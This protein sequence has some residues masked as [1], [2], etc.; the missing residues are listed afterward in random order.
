MKDTWLARL[1]RRLGVAPLEGVQAALVALVQAQAQTRA[2]LEKVEKE[3]NRAGKEQFK[4]NALAQAQQEQFKAALEQLRQ[5]GVQREDELSERRAHL[6]QA[7]GQERVEVVRALFPVLDGLGEA[8]DS[9]E[10]LLKG[11]AAVRR[12]TLAQRLRAAVRALAGSASPGMLPAPSMAAWL[13]G[14]GLVQ[15]RLLQVLAAA[16]VEPIETT[17][18]SFDPHW[19]RAV[20]VAPAGAGAEP[21]TVVAQIRGGYA[22]GDRVLR[23]A[24]VAVAR[25]VIT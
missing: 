19:H 5:A 2:A 18:K 3:L 15:E 12:L 24:E 11:T 4:S 7:H 1:G 16:G 14:L 6:A 8:L 22:L 17:G 21:G 25:A 23:Y 13:E 10:R 9:G 20:E